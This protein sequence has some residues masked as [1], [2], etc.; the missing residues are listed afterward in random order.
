MVRLYHISRE[1]GTFYLEPNGKSYP[2]DAD[3]VLS[4]PIRDIHKTALR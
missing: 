3:V 1:T 4:K 2:E